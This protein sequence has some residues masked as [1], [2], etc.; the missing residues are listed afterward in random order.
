MNAPK[1]QN[2]KEG[3]IKIIIVAIRELLSLC[4]SEALTDM[5]G[6]QFLCETSHCNLV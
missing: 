2:S 3:T 4:R 6:I 1:V 5:T